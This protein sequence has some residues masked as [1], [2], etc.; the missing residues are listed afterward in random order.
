MLCLFHLDPLLFDLGQGVAPGFL[1]AAAE[2]DH[3]AIVLILLLGDAVDVVGPAELIYLFR[4]LLDNGLGDGRG[5][6][7]DQICVLLY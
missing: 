5:L 7:L 1:K 6:T 4:Q 2:Q 3:G